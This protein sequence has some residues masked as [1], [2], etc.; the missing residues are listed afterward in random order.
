MTS[1]SKMSYRGRSSR[2][3]KAV[4][5]R[6][7]A[8]RLRRIMRARKATTQSELL[9]TLLSEEEER[10]ESERVLRETTGCAAASDFDDR[11]L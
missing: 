2:K 5:V 9:N 7:P 10:I 11:L 1:M 4:T 8:E 3:K 6:L